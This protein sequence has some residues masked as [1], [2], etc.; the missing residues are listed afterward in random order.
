MYSDDGQGPIKALAKG[1][2]I[3]LSFDFEKTLFDISENQILRKFKGM[4]FLNF[5]QGL[6]SWNLEALIWVMI[7]SPDKFIEASNSLNESE[8]LYLQFMLKDTSKEVDVSEAR[9]A[10]K[11]ADFDSPRKK[12]LIHALKKWKEK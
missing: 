10:L 4:Y 11:N 2:S 12:K 5:K 6:N 9:A 1:D 8:F 3:A 7:K